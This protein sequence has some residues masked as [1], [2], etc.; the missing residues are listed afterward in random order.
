M[1]LLLLHY[2]HTDTATRDIEAVVWGLIFPLIAYSTG[3][4]AYARALL[5]VSLCLA[6]SLLLP[7]SLRTRYAIITNTPT[8]HPSRTASPLA[9]AGSSSVLQAACVTDFIPPLTTAA[10][11]TTTTSHLHTSLA[12]PSLGQVL[13]L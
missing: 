13:R 11:T 8:N 12:L 4:L 6:L 7:L 1:F 2:S 3:I 5:S 9:C 10:T